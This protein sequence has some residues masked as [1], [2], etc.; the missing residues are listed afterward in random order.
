MT[1]RDQRVRE[2]SR[3]TQPALAKLY[4]RMGGLGGMYEPEKWSKDD[5]I[6][7]VLDIESRRSAQPVTA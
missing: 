4:R 7:S 3:M 2:L 1:T 6:S 5:L